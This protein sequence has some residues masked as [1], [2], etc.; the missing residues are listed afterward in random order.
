MGKIMDENEKYLRK[1]FLELSERAWRNNTYFFS[2]FLNE[3][4]LASY[5]EIETELSPAGSS[6]Y[7]GYDYAERRMIRFGS[8]EAFGYEEAFPIRCLQI[9][10]R[11]EKFADDLTH[12][13]FLG[14]VMS[15]GIERDV[16]GD[17]LVKGNGCYLFCEEKIADYLLENLLQIRHTQIRCSLTD[18]TPDEFRP[19]TIR[20]ETQVASERIDAVVARLCGVSRNE[21]LA[22]FRAKKVFLGGKLCEN[23]SRVIKPQELLSVR[24]YGKFRYLGNSHLTR[25]GR[26]NIV[27]EKYV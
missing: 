14:A 6:V 5:Y 22:L 20:L 13:D 18:E 8:P 16:I 12:R 4:E 23:S 15:L 17:I 21:S 9:V 7:G 2:D 10:P 27:Y 26:L 19:E 11:L 3:A 24:G 1:R 25:K